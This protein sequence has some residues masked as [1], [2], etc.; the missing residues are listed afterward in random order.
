MRSLIGAI[1]PGIKGRKRTLIFRF[2]CDA[3][4]DGSS[5][6]K[7]KGKRHVPRTFVV[8][9]LIAHEDVWN[10]L[11][12]AWTTFNNYFGVSRFH[13]SHLNAKTYEYEGWDDERKIQY[14]RTLLRLLAMCGR[15]LGAV[16][17][18]IFADE[19]RSVISEEGQK[20]LGSPY[21][22]SFNSCIAGVAQLMKNNPPEDQFSVILDKDEG[23]QEACDS[24]YW[25]KDDSEFVHRNRLLSCTPFNMEEAVCLQ[26]A[27]LVAFETFKAL[28]RFRANQIGGR[29]P[30]K[31]L[32]KHNLVRDGYYDRAYL[33]KIAP[34][35][36]NT[37]CT[38]KYL[39][40]IPDFQ[41]YKQMEISEELDQFNTAMD[42]ILRADPKAVKDAMEAD[43]AANAEKRKAKNQPS[44]S[45]PASSGKD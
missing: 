31:H 14:S 24:F 27:D 11:E 45:V 6:D 21:M 26:A 36:E 22:A 43:K 41:G 3:S 7:I 28:E 9:G 39:V 23:W 37:E 16:G 32:L 42:T 13:A 44:S 15:E 4:Y 20:K 2:Y 12:G 29:Y 30:M 34:W 25:M 5:K 18:G 40:H 33:Q 38:G 17:M 8:A 1:H 19:Y 10:A 35:I